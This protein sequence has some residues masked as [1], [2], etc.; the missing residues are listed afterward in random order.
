MSQKSIKYKYELTTEFNRLLKSLSTQNRNWLFYYEEPAVSLRETYGDN[1][2][3]FYSWTAKA[4]KKWDTPQL[5]G[6]AR[7]FS[8]LLATNA[9]CYYI[10]FEYSTSRCNCST[11]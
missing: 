9:A 8:W 1:K 5:I 11:R 10:S 7:V 6:M 3:N 4:V 2:G